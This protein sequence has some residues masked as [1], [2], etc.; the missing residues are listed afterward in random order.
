ME[1]GGRP[2]DTY[3][4]AYPPLYT[5]HADL[6]PTCPSFRLCARL[7]FSSFVS[8]SEETSLSVSAFSLL[9][10]YRHTHTVRAQTHKHLHPQTRTHPAFCCYDGSEL[11]KHPRFLSLS[12]T[13]AAR[14]S[15]SMQVHGDC[16]LSTLFL[17]FSL[18]LS[19]S[20]FLSWWVHIDLVWHAHFSQN[21]LSTHL[22]Q[23]IGC[24]ANR[25][26]KQWECLKQTAS[27]KICP[28]QTW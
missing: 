3:Q 22:L 1:H 21:T 7:F 18:S 27:R 12:L 13:K 5:P 14:L 15:L 8:E 9:C 20:F 25:Q 10:V 4:Y 24:L 28:I 11:S 6:L 17:S 23:Y 2:P 26:Q 16:C 19:L